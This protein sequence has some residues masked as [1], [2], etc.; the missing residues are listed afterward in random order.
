MAE[1]ISYIDRSAESCL[2]SETTN[3]DCGQCSEFAQ[4]LLGLT[5]PCGFEFPA[6]PPVWLDK[7]LFDVGIKFYHRN[8]VGI[9]ASSGEALIMGLALPTFYKPLAFSGATS[10]NK[11]AALMRYMETGRHI[12]GRWYGGKPWEE[13]CDAAESLNLVNK[14]HKHVADMITK[15]GDSFEDKVERAFTDY[16]VE[17]D[18][19]KILK[20]ELADLKESFDMPSEYYDY[21]NGKQAFSEFDMTLVQAAFFA[22]VLVYPDHYGSKSATNHEL[23][24]FIHV[25]RVFGYYMGISEE[26]NAAQFGLERTLVVGNEVMDK[27]LKPCMLY[28]NDQSII[29]AQKILAK[30]TNYYVWVYRNYNMVGFRM[31]RLWNSFSWKQRCAYYS[32][33]LFLGYLYPLPLVRD[34]INY[35]AQKFMTKIWLKEKVKSQ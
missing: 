15:A 12:Y 21:M 2:N 35:M 34:F 19:A 10:K 32:R 31:D 24:G 28:V 7:D 17:G 16:E 9:L 1:N 27:I 4:L 18:Q 23:E 25:W 29:M 14:M 6:S 5:S 8:L 13:G 3:T 22:A 26:N 30:P 33:S 11:R 20:E